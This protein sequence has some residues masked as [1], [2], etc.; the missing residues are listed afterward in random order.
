MDR[1]WFSAI[2]NKKTK[3]NKKPYT[4]KLN[5]YLLYDNLVRKDIKKEI[6]DFLEFNE[7]EGTTYPNLWDTMNAVLRAK[8][9]VL[10]AFI[11]ELEKSYTRSSI[12]HLKV[13]EQK[14]ANTHKRSRWQ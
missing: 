3:Q 10:C 6:K 7:N 13:L 5:N 8:F 12:A 1:S 4:W 14:E 9:I 2:K 11:K